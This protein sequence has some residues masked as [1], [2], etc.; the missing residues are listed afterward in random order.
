MAY[1]KY[2]L[3]DTNRVQQER[4]QQ[5]IRSL[6]SSCLSVYNQK[7][8][9]I[10]PDASML[11]HFREQKHTCEKPNPDCKPYF[12][13]HFNTVAL[14]KSVEPIPPREDLNAEPIILPPST[15]FTEDYF[16]SVIPIVINNSIEYKKVQASYF[17][18]RDKY[19]NAIEKPF[20][21]TGKYIAHEMI[22]QLELGKHDT[23]VVNVGTGD[24]KS[25][26]ARHL[27]KFYAE[28][29]YIVLVAC[30]FILLTN[31][32]FFELKGILNKKT[33]IINYKD[34]DENNLDEHVQANV[35]CITI[36]CL[37]RNPGGDYENHERTEFGR[38]QSKIKK[39]Y[40]DNLQS[41]CLRNHKEVIIFFDEIH[42]GI[43][44]FKP[45]LRKN[46]KF[47]KS[48]V[49]KVFVF[50]ATYT[51]ASFIV[52]AFL[53]KTLTNKQM[54]IYNCDRRKFPMQANLHINITDKRYTAKDL[55]PLRYLTQVIDEALS[56]QHKI[57]LLV[58]TKSLTEALTD[59]Q[60]QEPLA[61]YIC[62]LNPNI[63]VGKE[64]QGINN[65]FDPDR[66]N[67]G[68]TFSTGISITDALNTFIIITPVF[69]GPDSQK[70]ASIF[71]DG[72]P[73]IIQAVARLRNG[74][75]IHVFMHKP[76]HVIRDG[77]L[78]TAP[79]FLTDLQRSSYRDSNDQ[80]KLIKKAHV[81]YNHHIRNLATF[82]NIDWNKLDNLNRENFILVKSQY[83][84]ASKYE[85]FGKKVNPFII[86]AA[87]HNQFTNCTLKTIN[88]I[89]ET[90]DPYVIAE[91]GAETII[92]DLRNLLRDDIEIRI[93]GLPDWSA[94]KLLFDEIH[95]QTVDGV[96]HKERGIIYKGKLVKYE[97]SKYHPAITRALINILYQFKHGIAYDYNTSSHLLE[98]IYLA[99]VSR[100]TKKDANPDNQKKLMRNNLKVAY[101]ILGE[102]GQLLQRN[103]I[104]GDPLY[105]RTIDENLERKICTALH[106][107]RENDFYIRNKIFSF[108]QTYH[109]SIHSDGSII[110]HNWD[111]T[112]RHKI[113]LKGLTDIFYE[114]TSKIEKI[115]G[116]PQRV[117]RITAEK[118]PP[119]NILDLTFGFTI[120]DYDHYLQNRKSRRRQLKS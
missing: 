51:E 62:A 58:A 98:N 16:T 95:T 47:W 19:F 86:W 44:N 20:E 74:G 22:E 43:N 49:K 45:Q 97:H 18:N 41:Y 60:S 39:K 111:V 11:N 99:P 75:D 12:E 38:T 78:E 14:L 56:K 63:L 70:L 31:E 114:S 88:L 101:T 54:T 30:P 69:V 108:L 36:N 1:K 100:I 103:V 37:M 50:S 35:H 25:Y 53:T 52:L 48:L 2:N 5:M 119:D 28:S 81:S 109:F 72:S 102:V 65:Q 80:F 113:L 64:T 66:I 57:N 90:P 68:T 76:T 105:L 112:E 83:E 117:R 67:I 91:I 106:E 26:T 40:L 34:L 17:N 71:M 85:I 21:F 7:R 115:N 73:A 118:L 92:P 8:N 59:P 104:F 4:I 33:R 27:I 10:Q 13:N 79:L 94:M 82:G 23:T 87:Y 116:K 110:H 55:S 15:L 89:A 61:K 42:A 32:N 6:D 107:L 29:G 120:E 96:I 93:K 9:Y 77:Y 24:G 84:L 3:V 46:L